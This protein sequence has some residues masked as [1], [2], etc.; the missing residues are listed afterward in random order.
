MESFS[1]TLGIRSGVNNSWIEGVHPR[2]YE[3][4]AAK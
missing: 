3:E 2:F 1:D 4:Q